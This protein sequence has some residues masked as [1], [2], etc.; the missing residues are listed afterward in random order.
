[1]TCLS[2]S[3][4]VLRTAAKLLAF[5][6]NR[7]HAKLVQFDGRDFRFLQEC[8]MRTLHWTWLAAIIV[9]F[10]AV[11]TAGAIEPK[12]LPNDTE[13]VFTVNLRQILDS[14]LFKTNK[15][16]VA[17]GKAALEN[18]AGGNPVM[19][20]LKTAGFDIFRD[21]QSI[22]VANN[23]GKDPTVSVKMSEDMVEA[24]KKA[25]SDVKLT[26][27]PEAGHNSW[28]EAYND[29]QLYQWLLQHER[30]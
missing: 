2:L 15:D 27:Y 25:G 21:L 8:S 22:T 24:L 28:T 16:A 12:Y 7:E 10:A 23:G 18:Q 17:Q 3:R 9:A 14:D 13:M 4:A 6:R 19:K 1:M 20:Y 11:A 29:P 5:F 30:K 26:I